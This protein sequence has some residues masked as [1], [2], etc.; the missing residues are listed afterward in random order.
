MV[1][2]LLVTFVLL[3]YGDG[4]NLTGTMLDLIQTHK[5]TYMLVL[6]PVQH[7]ILILDNIAL[8]C[9]AGNALNSGDYNVFLVCSRSS[10]HRWYC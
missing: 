8:G 1:S 5:R 3:L 4:S 10:S 2:K 6:V 9:N 7:Q